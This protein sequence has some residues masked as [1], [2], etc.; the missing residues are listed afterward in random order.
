MLRVSLIDQSER[1]DVRTG[2]DRDELLTVKLVG[3]RRCVPVGVR[4]KRPEPVAGR[5]VGR[6]KRSAVVSE[7]NQSRRRRKRAAPRRASARLREFPFPIPC[8]QIDCV[9]QSLRL[10]SGVDALCAAAV[11]FALLP[12]DGPL[13]VDG[14][15]LENLKIVQPGRRVVRR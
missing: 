9:Q 11:R 7:E 2:G 12:D 10:R 1:D 13:R 6:G 15:L 4:L 3:H 8:L 14:A 5:G